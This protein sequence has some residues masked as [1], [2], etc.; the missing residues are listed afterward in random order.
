MPAT[1][2]CDLENIPAGAQRGF[3]VAVTAVDAQTIN[4]VADVTSPTP[5]PNDENNHAIIEHEITGV[6]DIKIAKGA[7]PGSVTVGDTLTF[8]L[9]VR[10][11]A[12]QKQRM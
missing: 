6:A 5:D 10:T 7:D 9:T 11:W 1:F 12:R 3:H 8:S 2:E 4:N